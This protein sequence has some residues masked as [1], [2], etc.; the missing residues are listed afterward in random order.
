MH[1]E[2]TWL[3]TLIIAFGQRIMETLIL[4]KEVASALG[5]M[6]FTLCIAV[7]VLLIQCLL[8]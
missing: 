3:D 2:L 7:L 5:V 8:K 1:P 6:D 4:A